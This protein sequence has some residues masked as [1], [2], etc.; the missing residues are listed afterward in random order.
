[1]KLGSPG[2]RSLL[3]D[4]SCSEEAG[5]SGL[6]AA[7]LGE[8]ERADGWFGLTPKFSRMRRGRNSPPRRS[9]APHVGCNATLGEA[10]VQQRLTRGVPEWLRV[11]DSL[12][13][14]SEACPAAVRLR[15]DQL[16]RRRC[17]PPEGCRTDAEAGTAV[18]LSAARMC[19]AACRRCPAGGMLLLWMPSL[20]GRLTP[21]VGGTAFGGA[22]QLRFGGY[23][24]ATILAQGVQRLIGSR[25]RA[26]GT[27]K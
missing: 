24:D 25:C 23:S 20:R 18:E 9:R 3:V 11:F 22:E 2:R 26:D 19:D 1:V 16:A 5:R 15:V 6:P 27:L 13:C 12:C 4:V 17:T 8:H 14:T 10:A 7:L 21:L